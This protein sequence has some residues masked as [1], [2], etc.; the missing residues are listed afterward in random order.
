MR[1]SRCACRICCGLPRWNTPSS[2]KPSSMPRST[3]GWTADGAARVDR[4]AVEDSGLMLS[5]IHDVLRTLIYAG[6]G[7][8]DADVDVSFEPPTRDRID[9]LT[10][11]TISLV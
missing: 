1:A 4:C 9:G 6:A 8:S 7:F 2:R 5:E 11:P 3:A 10:R